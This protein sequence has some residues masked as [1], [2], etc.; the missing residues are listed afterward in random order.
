MA[1]QPSER[2][3]TLIEPTL[4]DMGYELVRVLISGHRRPTLQVMAERSDQEPM[5]VEDCA[6]ISHAISALLDVED[7][8]PSTYRLEVSSPG[9][10][11]P[12]VRRADF[13]R[14]AG[15]DARL[16]TEL[17][18]DGRRRF[19]GRLLGLVEDRV[20]LRLAEGE[21][22]LPLAAIKKARLVATDALL[23][24]AQ[25]ERRSER[26]WPRV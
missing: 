5:T 24:A 1:V 6:A 20:R 11:R 21:R 23:S 15:F 10:D 13:E 2:V 22:E 25:A 7:P 12:L 17:P 4:N 16:E 3:A 8:I 19:Q 9:I 18:I 14:F 26:R